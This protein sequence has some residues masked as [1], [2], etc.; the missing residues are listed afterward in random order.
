MQS[1]PLQDSGIEMDDVEELEVH[2]LGEVVVPEARRMLT[3]ILEQM[4]SYQVI[5]HSIPKE[6]QSL[7]TI[8]Q[9]V[10]IVGRMRESLQ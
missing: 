4:S 10:G 9:T 7:V 8:R 3:T 1:P 6:F 5:K 2:G